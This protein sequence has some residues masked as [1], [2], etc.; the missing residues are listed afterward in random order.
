MQKCTNSSWGWG[1]G[2]NM[3]T[4]R[5]T[6][7]RGTQKLHR[8]CQREF[9]PPWVCG[10]LGHLLTHTYGPVTYFLSAS[11]QEQRPGITQLGHCAYFGLPSSAESLCRPLGEPC[12]RR[13]RTMSER[14]T[15]KYGKTYLPLNQYPLKLCLYLLQTE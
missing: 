11:C 8:H 3:Q 12:V 4:A 14:S 7:G 2:Q 13:S 15:G 9:I 10:R 1:E 6:A 5:I